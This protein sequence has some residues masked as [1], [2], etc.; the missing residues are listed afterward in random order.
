MISNETCY[1][2]LQSQF[3]GQNLM[4]AALRGHDAETVRYAG[5][6]IC[7]LLRSGAIDFNQCAAI[8]GYQVGDPNTTIEPISWTLLRDCPQWMLEAYVD[9]MTK[10][11]EAGQKDLFSMSIDF[12]TWWEMRE[13][14]FDE[15]FILPL[16]FPNG[17]VN[18]TIKALRARGDGLLAERLLKLTNQAESNDILQIDSLFGDSEQ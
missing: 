15:Q 6:L 10:L 5:G 12:I 14:S 9:L 13:P 7:Q 3:D 1:Q 4:E 8:I 11:R 17:D 16:H 18:A 2:L